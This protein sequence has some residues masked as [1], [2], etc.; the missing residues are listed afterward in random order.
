MEREQFE[1][2]LR[3]LEPERPRGET[4]QAISGAFDRHFALK[5]GQIAGFRRGFGLWQ[6]Q[7]AFT[8]VELLVVIA[9]V[10]ILA[11]L[12]LPVLGKVKEM[13]RQIE[14]ANNAR[15]IFLG[16]NAYADD[17]RRFS[18]AGI[19]VANYQYNKTVL[20]G[21][22]NYLGVPSDYN[23][24]NATPP[25]ARCA[26]GGRYGHT[27]WEHHPGGNPNFAICLNY[28]L[29]NSYSANFKRVKN[30]SS[31]MLML[32]GGID[33]WNNLST[34]VWNID[35][36]S[37]V[38]FRHNHKANAVFVDGHTKPLDYSDVPKTY[39]AADDPDDFWMEH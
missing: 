24:N 22:A 9:I 31:R 11:S 35:A 37:K 33:N 12:L 26:N 19:N 7:A 10:S 36:R 14:C 30:T 23:Y 18:P 2:F 3:K 13:A 20:G 4:W 8:L 5:R 38:A 15:Q 6:R 28:F 39:L 27:N 25:I 32:E 29:V 16:I 34:N 1:S 17:Y 21:M